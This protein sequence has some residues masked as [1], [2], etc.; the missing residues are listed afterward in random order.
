MLNEEKDLTPSQIN[1]FFE[2]LRKYQQHLTRT[3]IN[4]P[5]THEYS[6][7][8]GKITEEFNKQTL[9]PYLEESTPS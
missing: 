1:D 5:S 7:S 8:Q 3:V 9:K 2:V 4:I 6:Y